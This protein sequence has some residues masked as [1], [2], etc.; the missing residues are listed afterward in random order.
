MR[1]AAPHGKALRRYKRDCGFQHRDSSGTEKEMDMKA[2]T[3]EQ[4]DKHV[5]GE[6]RAC[7]VMFS[8]ADCWICGLV[9]PV[10]HDIEESG[11]YADRFEFF[12]IDVKANR[13]LFKEKLGL[14]GVPQ[15]FFFKDG[16]VAGKLVGEKSEADYR[17]KIE[18][19][20]A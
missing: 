4:F 12:E 19:I 9:E 3:T 7:L 2:L 13:D 8:M 11:D 5:I 1:S 14:R 20:L 18:S 16:E 15:V 17:E 10:L 6:K